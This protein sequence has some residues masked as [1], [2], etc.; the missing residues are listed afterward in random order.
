VD[1]VSAADRCTLPPGGEC[2]PGA[3]SCA[4]CELYRAPPPRQLTLEL[5]AERGAHVRARIFDAVAAAGPAG[6]TFERIADRT[7]INPNTVRGRLSEL[8]RAGVVVRR[9]ARRRT[10]S[11]GR[12]SLYVVAPPRPA[13]PAPGGG[14]LG[15]VFDLADALTG[16]AIRATLRGD[17]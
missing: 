9:N 12:A 14:Y 15:A 2:P 5:R 11:G 1:A 13:A 8:E 7:S 16:G 17:S 4:S 3:L 6:A 10:T